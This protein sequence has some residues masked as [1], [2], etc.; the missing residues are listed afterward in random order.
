MPP[1][2]GVGITSLNRETSLPDI[3]AEVRKRHAEG[4]ICLG[5]PNVDNYEAVKA[6]DRQQAMKKPH[7]YFDSMRYIQEIRRFKET[8]PKFDLKLKPSASSPNVG[9]IAKSCAGA[10]TYVEMLMRQSGKD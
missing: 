2:G 8:D 9:T 6:R 5:K 10:S 4:P 3:C 1:G 7:L